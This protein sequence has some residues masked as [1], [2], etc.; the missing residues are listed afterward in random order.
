MLLGLLVPHRHFEESGL[1][2][3]A[4]NAVRRPSTDPQPILDALLIED[5][6][7]GVFLGDHRVVGPHPLNKSSV[8]GFPGI[9]DDDAIEGALLGAGSG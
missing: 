1:A 3:E 6:A 8:A 7:L 9:G 5:N 2:Q 4:G